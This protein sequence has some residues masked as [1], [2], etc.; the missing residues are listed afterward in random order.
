MLRPVQMSKTT[1]LFLKSDSEEVMDSINRQGVFHITLKTGDV[2]SDLLNRVR[3]LIVRLD[4]LIAK[5]GVLSGEMN[6]QPRQQVLSEALDWQ[7][8]MDAVEKE[9]SEYEHRIKEVDQSVQAEERLRSSLNLWVPFATNLEKVA[10]LPPLPF[11]RI[12]LLPLYQKEIRPS[13]LTVLLPHPSLLLIVSSNPVTVLVICLKEDLD[14]VR[15][16]SEEA[17]YAPMPHLEG[18]SE[19]LSNLREIISTSEKKLN[20]ISLK[21]EEIKRSLVS[22]MPNLLYLKSLLSDALSLLT[23]REKA[24]FEKRWMILEGYVPTEN[25]PPLI[26]ELQTK[27]AGRIISLSKEEHSS[28]QV[29]VTFKYP[30]FFKL[31][32]SITTLYGVPSYTEINPT[33]IIAISF[34]L[35][36]GLMFGDLGHGIM[37]AVLGFIF[38][39]YTKSVSKIGLF[40]MICGISGAIVG[41]ALYGEAF[42]K[43]IGYHTI[44]S[45]GEDMMS[46]FKFSLYIGVAQISLGLSILIINNLI[47]KKRA[48]AFLVNFPKLLLYLSFMY[49][50]FHYGLNITQ[51]FAGPIFL[52]LA[53]AVFMLVAKPIWAFIKHGKKESLPV[54]GELGFEVFDNMIRFVSN[55]VSYLRIFAMVMAHLQLTAV[56]YS[57]GGIA[58]GGTVGMVLSLLLAALGNVFVVLLE[59]VLVL[60]QD[61]RLHFY[62]WFSKFYEDGGVRFTPFKLALG[63]PTIRG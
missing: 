37:L 20:E 32:E 59:G 21:N 23:I 41:G 1:L 58:G 53:P 36:F 61:L 40:L 2:T 17:G 46:L 12:A 55:T 5:V 7:S 25:L 47:Q 14:K 18:I 8:L 44:F 50:V 15:R 45:P 16:I 49:V 31:F 19:S 51:W 9:L 62:E 3:D 54:L 27:L 60:A 29:P 52:I 38:Y 28:P 34:P 57:L 4:E 13:D 48:D 43:H 30:R 6:I 42:G 10:L 56:F 39:K 11:K 35:F 22:L 24:S 33:P 63:V 26:N